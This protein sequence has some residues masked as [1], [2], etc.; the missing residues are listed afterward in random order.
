[1][2][3]DKNK[4][5]TALNADEVKV[6]SK[7]YFADELKDLRAFVS[8]DNNLSTLAD[9]MGE[10]Y[11]HRFD[12]G[13]VCWNL[14]YLVEEPEEEKYR[15]YEDSDEMIEDFKERAKKHYNANFFKCPMFHTSIWVKN[16]GE[17]E[18]HLITDFSKIIVKTSR[19]TIFLEDLFE[20]Y[21]YL[22]GTPCG[23]KIE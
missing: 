10:G 19:D 5:Y 20:D 9:V 6:G 12:G 1:M 23:K 8:K 21:T 11:E 22:D 4:V 3:F 14:F 15:P 2:T 16:K 13:D 18:T 17:E 7:G